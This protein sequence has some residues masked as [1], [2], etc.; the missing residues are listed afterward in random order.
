MS[1]RSSKKEAMRMFDDAVDLIETTV[2]SNNSVL[3]SGRQLK[4][5]MNYERRLNKLLEQDPDQKFWKVLGSAL[6]V[7]IHIS[8][9]VL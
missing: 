9:D 6:K 4:S 8:N 5:L 7:A 1:K 2:E 3:K